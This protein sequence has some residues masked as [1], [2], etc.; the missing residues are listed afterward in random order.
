MSTF[1]DTH[2]IEVAGAQL[3]LQSIDYQVALISLESK[4]QFLEV[5]PI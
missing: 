5:M 4:I 3:G 2:Q 1:P